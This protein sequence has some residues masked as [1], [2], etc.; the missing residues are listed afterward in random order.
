MRSYK[1]CICLENST[2]ENYFTE[3]FVEAVV[4]GCVPVYKAH[5]SLVNT[6]LDGAYWIDP[7]DYE[8]AQDVIQAA[9][10]E[11]LAKIQHRNMFWLRTNPALRKSSAQAVFSRIASIFRKLVTEAE[12]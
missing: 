5:R 4:A 10:D 3:K 1:A 11:D 9:L 12:D 2:E 7:D 6:Y 8:T